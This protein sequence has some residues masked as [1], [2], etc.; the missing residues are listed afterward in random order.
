LVGLAGGGPMITAGVDMTGWGG[1]R[2]SV[3][4][5]VPPWRWSLTY[6]Y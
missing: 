2:G 3:T 5:F 4:D 1:E 6:E